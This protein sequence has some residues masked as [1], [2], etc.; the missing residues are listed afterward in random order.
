MTTTGGVGCLATFL[1]F[2]AGAAAFLVALIPLALLG[3]A[4]GLTGG[5]FRA[6]VFAVALVAGLAV[7][8]VVTG[9]AQ[10][11]RGGPAEGR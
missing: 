8:R 2:L 6:V 9:R 1:A 4:V 11:R 10:A 3:G 5:A 7:V